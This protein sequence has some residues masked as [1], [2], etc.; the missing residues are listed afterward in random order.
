MNYFHKKV[1]SFFSICFIFST[2]FLVFSCSFFAAKTQPEKIYEENK[3]LFLAEI[4]SYIDKT[5]NDL[6]DNLHYGKPTEYTTK[7]NKNKQIIKAEIIYEKVYNFHEQKYD[8]LI[9]FTTDET[10]KKIVKVD[11]N[12]DKCYYL[13]QY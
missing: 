8:C 4:N 11:Y 2:F 7:I 9:T 5:P 1:V 6:Y 3:E 13:A 10:Q 12:N